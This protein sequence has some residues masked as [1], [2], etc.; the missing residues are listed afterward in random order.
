MHSCVNY[1]QESC[2]F[3][4]VTKFHEQSLRGSLSGGED[5][6]V[7]HSCPLRRPAEAI[8]M[9]GSEGRRSLWLRPHFLPL[10][11]WLPLNV[12]CLV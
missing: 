5:S 3:K 12:S 1:S 9:L 11:S 6:A 10:F 7:S 2:P 8:G 4:V